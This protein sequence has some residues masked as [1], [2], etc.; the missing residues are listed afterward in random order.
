MVVEVIIPD[1][2]VI[3]PP[4]RLCSDKTK[5][6]SL[7]QREGISKMSNGSKTQMKQTAKTTKYHEQVNDNGPEYERVSNAGRKFKTLSPRKNIL[8]KD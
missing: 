7:E 6:I 2:L 4:V 5:F 8:R 1:A 3:G